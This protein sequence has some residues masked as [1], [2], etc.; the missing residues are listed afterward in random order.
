MPKPDKPDYD[1]LFAANR[2][3]IIGIR[4]V[5]HN[6]AHCTRPDPSVCEPSAKLGTC[7]TNVDVHFGARL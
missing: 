1:P 4:T 6:E 7:E 5:L 3:N 2:H